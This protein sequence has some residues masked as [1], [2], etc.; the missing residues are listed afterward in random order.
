MSPKALSKTQNYTE[1]PALRPAFVDQNKISCNLSED[2]P[3][4]C[5]QPAIKT[6]VKNYKI[7]NLLK[8]E[9]EY[10]KSKATKC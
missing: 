1:N 8:K 6:Y 4:A 10:Q 3:H 9:V 7:L 5:C 2:V